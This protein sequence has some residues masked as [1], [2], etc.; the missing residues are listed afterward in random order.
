MSESIAGAFQFQELLLGGETAT[1]A[2]EG[3]VASDYPMAR[4][5]DG[6]RIGTIGGGH[7]PDGQWLADCLGKLA[8]RNRLAVRNRLESLPD[9]LLEIGADQQQRQ[10][11]LM[12][13]AGKIFIQLFDSLFNNWSAVYNIAS[14]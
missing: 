11:K 12:A 14:D 10:I 1:I 3:V 9:R 7:C 5:N 6:N 2:C 13:N 8:I 4:Q